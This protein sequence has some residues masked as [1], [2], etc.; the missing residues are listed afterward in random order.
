MTHKFT[1]Q[2]VLD[3]KEQVEDLLQIQRSGIEGE[4]QDLERRIAT[5]RAQWALTSQSGTGPDDEV[6]DPAQ[7][8]EWAEY[9]AALERRIHSHGETLHEVDER[10]QAKRAELE[11]NYKEREL[12]QRLKAKRAAAEEKEEQRREVRALDDVNTGQY[13]RRNGN[14]HTPDLDGHNGKGQAISTSRTGNGHAN[15]TSRNGNGTR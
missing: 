10:L 12:L 5:L 15:G 6:L 8:E 3:L 14:G 2:R 13:L 9:L 4:R 1:L 11:A 7:R